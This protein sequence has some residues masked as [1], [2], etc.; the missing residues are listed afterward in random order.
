MN[1]K[2]AS[3]SPID[4]NLI[5]ENPINITKAKYKGN[6]II[7]KHD[8]LNFALTPNHRM[9]VRKFIKNKGL[10]DEYSFVNAEDLG[11]YSGLM[12]KFYQNKPRV[13]CIT[14]DAEITDNGNILSELDIPM[15][16]WLQFLGI[17]LA[18]YRDLEIKT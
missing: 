15:D 5:F 16:D 3:A 12:T 9:L 14:L 11:H 13:D 1:D 10:S 7:G 2:L 6:L 17:Y 4:G 18:G 8:S